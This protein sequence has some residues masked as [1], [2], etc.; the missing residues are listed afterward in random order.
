MDQSTILFPK[1]LDSR[2]L[3]L[4]NGMIFFDLLRG[5]GEISLYNIDL[6]HHTCGKNNHVLVGPQFVRSQNIQ[7]RFY[8]YYNAN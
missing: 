7:V 6:I 4:P 5:Q 2:I 1:F 3:L 8:A